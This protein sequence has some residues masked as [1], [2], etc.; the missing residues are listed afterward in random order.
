MS[1][2]EFK[3]LL[4]IHIV[5]VIILMIALSLS[6]HDKTFYIIMASSV[7]AE[8]SILMRILVKKKQ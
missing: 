7:L 3:L 2:F 5:I 6:L 4:V 1:L 8:I